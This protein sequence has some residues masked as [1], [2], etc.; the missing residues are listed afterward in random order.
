MT[1]IL[2]ALLGVVLLMLGFQGF[3]FAR[4]RMARGRSVQGLTG[5]LGRAVASGR[6]VLVYFYSPSCRSCRV[7][8]PVV[9][10]LQGEYPDVMK[11]NIAEDMAPARALHVMGTPSVVFI[12]EGK[13][14]E[15]LVGVQPESK[16]RALLGA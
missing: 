9:D 1:W 7:Q 11:V 13:V 8:G 6:K 12:A 5:E 15:F 2:F 16:L 4:A 3:A 14:Q 10:R